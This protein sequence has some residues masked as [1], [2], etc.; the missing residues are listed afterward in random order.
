[1]KMI[2]VSMF[3]N[4]AHILKAVEPDLKHKTVTYIPTASRKEWFGCFVRLGKWR[5]KKMGMA[6]DE[7]ELSTSS[8]ET[9][10]CTLEKNDIIYVGG[11]N[12]FFLLQELKRTGA[13]RLLVQEIKKGKLYVGESAGAIVT[14]PDIGYSAEMDHAGKAPDLKDYSGL[15]LI[16]FYIVPHYK[17]CGLGR[18]AEKIIRR[19]SAKMDV[20]AIRDSQA[21]L[22]DNGDVR[23]L[24]RSFGK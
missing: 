17:N 22:I 4:V 2:L 7:L 13:D 6:V 18:A 23:I 19:Y 10:R 16:D 9:I 21:V 1:M 3:L 5:L 20:K 12:T 24:G 11:G 8:Y 15:N 14:A